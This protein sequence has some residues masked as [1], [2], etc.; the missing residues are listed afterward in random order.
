VHEWVARPASTSPAAAARRPGT[1]RP[2]RR[3]LR[4]VHDEERHDHD[5]DQQR[6]EQ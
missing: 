6:M 1:T 5:R 3:I 4:V 2:A